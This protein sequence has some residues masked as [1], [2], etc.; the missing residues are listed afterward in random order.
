MEKGSKIK[1]RTMK[2]NS[3][4]SRYDDV[5]LRILGGSEFALD[6]LRQEGFKPTPIYKS[7]KN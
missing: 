2:E 5:A 7:D 6:V 3:R 4:I 1:R